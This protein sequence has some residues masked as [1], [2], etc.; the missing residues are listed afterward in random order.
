MTFNNES[1]KRGGTRQLTRVLLS[2]ILA[3]ACL[4]GTPLM[5]GAKPG[6]GIQIRNRSAAAWV[7]QSGFSQNTEENSEP[8]PEPTI[9]E[10]MPPPP[11]VSPS[12]TTTKPTVPLSSEACPACPCPPTV[13]PMTIRPSMPYEPIGTPI[14]HRSFS[15][16]C[17]GENWR[18]Q[19][20]DR[21]NCSSNFH[22][23]THQHSLWMERFL[24]GLCGK[25]PRGYVH[26]T[27]GFPLRNFFLPQPDDPAYAAGP[28]TTSYVYDYPQ[29]IYQPNPC[30]VPP[31]G[32]YV[33]IITKAPPNIAH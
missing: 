9:R 8:Q 17:Y 14:C 12:M 27:S 11:P 15:G 10:I 19:N 31:A 30:R 7:K 5:A 32:P 24:C 1:Q 23:K 25:Q 20:W 26:D 21:S 28:T 2:G 6:R 29:Y 3:G 33:P 13:G 4:A 16:D 18:L 22:Y